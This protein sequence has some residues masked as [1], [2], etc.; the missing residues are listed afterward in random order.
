MNVVSKIVCK[1]AG[2]A[3]VSAA[4]Y[5]AY[6]YGKANSHR[7]SQ[8][9]TADHFERVHAATRT[10]G[11]ESEVKNFV[12]EKTRDFR[13]ENPL[14][15]IFGSIKGFVGGAL[16]SLGTNIIPVIFASMAL[17]GKGTASKIGAIGVAASALYT[18]AREGFGLGKHTP[19]D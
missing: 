6:C 18:I 1:T 7:V 14:I 15:S 11:T 19:V 10:L 12:Q 9:M 3:G 13:M 4:L 16:E 17:A 5:D 8:H 2:I